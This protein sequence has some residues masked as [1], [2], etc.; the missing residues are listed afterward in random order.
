MSGPRQRLSAEE[1]QE[2]IIKAAVDLAGEHGVDA[3]TTQDMAKAVGVTQGA[4]FR[5]FPS[6][7]LIWLGVI[8][9][10]RGRLMAVVDM[11][12]SQGSDPI[13]ALERVFFAHI[14]FVERHPA[15]PRLLFSDQLLR[16]N[17][18]IRLLIREILA[19][20]EAKIRTLLAEA[21]AR[22]QVSADL[23]EAQATMLYVS[24]IQ[25]LVM[26]VSILEQK[27]SLLDE[28]RR[29]FPFYLRAIGAA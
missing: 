1:R 16:K 12:A 25:G 20:Y 29:L 23:D 11:A 24:L 22:Q 3:V 7:D 21:K 28:A 26:R 14:G 15:I 19:G 2:E 27:G 6:K 9:W 5:H 13:D 18:R 17:P 10:V 4:I 8:H